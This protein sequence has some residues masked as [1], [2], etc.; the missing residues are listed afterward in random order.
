[1]NTFYE[2][3][4]RNVH[5]LSA[6]LKRSIISQVGDITEMFQEIQL[7]DINIEMECRFKGMDG[8]K[9]APRILENLDSR[10][11]LLKRVVQST[12]SNYNIP[13]YRG[14]S[15]T[16][17]ESKVD[18]ESTWMTKMKL[19]FPR[20]TVMGRTFD[21]FE[22]MG[23]KL[24]FS[25]EINSEPL[26]RVLLAS[27]GQDNTP[28]K[29]VKNRESYIDLSSGIAYDI[30]RVMQ[31][32]TNKVE[33]EIEMDLTT[34]YTNF[35][36]RDPVGTIK[37]FITRCEEE[38]RQTVFQTRSLLP[39][40]KIEDA[41]RYLNQC[42]GDERSGGWRISSKVPQ[43]RNIQTT[44]LL[45]DNYKKYAVTPKADG[46]RYFLM[47]RSSE[48]ILLQPP[49][50][51]KVLYE[52]KDIPVDWNGFIF[53]GELVEKDNWRP[54]NLTQAF[55]SQV[56]NYFCIFDV[57]GYPSGFPTQHQSDILE[58]INGVKGYFEEVRRQTSLGP[59]HWSNN[60]NAIYFQPQPSSRLSGPI[61]KTFIEIKPYDDALGTSWYAADAFFDTLLPKLR[62]KD[63]GI[64]LTPVN[65]DYQG[66]VSNMTLKWKPQ[67]MLT[68]DF[69]WADNKLYVSN[70]NS[71][72]ELVEQVFLGS[73][74]FPLDPEEVFITNP[75]KVLVKNGGIYE[76]LYDTTLRKFKVTRPRFDKT[77]PNSIRTA[78]QVW[79]D[80]HRPVSENL[81][82]GIGRDG[83]VECQKEALWSW[84]QNKISKVQGVV[85]DA[86]GIVP[87]DVFPFHIFTNGAFQT[88]MKNT[89]MVRY[90]N[91]ETN[92]DFP[93][94]RKVTPSNFTERI[95]LL[96]L[97]GQQ[98]AL[99]EGREGI[100]VGDSKKIS[101]KYIDSL[102]DLVSRSENIFVRSLPAIIPENGSSAFFPERSACGNEEELVFHYVSDDCV[103][104]DFS[105]GGLFWDVTTFT[106]SLTRVRAHKR[107]FGSESLIVSAGHRIT[108]EGKDMG[109]EHILSG[110]YFGMLW[111]YLFNVMIPSNYFHQPVS[112]LF[113]R[114]ASDSTPLED[115]F[116]GLNV[117]ADP[118]TE[119]VQ[120]V[121][122]EFVFTRS[123][124]TLRE[125]VPSSMTMER[126]VTQNPEY[127]DL[128][129]MLSKAMMILEVQTPPLNRVSYDNALV[130]KRANELRLLLG[131]INNINE[132]VK[133]IYQQ[134]DL[135]IV[136]VR[137]LKNSN[138][139][140][141]YRS[142][143]IL[144][145]TIHSPRYGFLI[146]E[147]RL[148]TLSLISLCNLLTY[149]G[150][151]LIY[152]SDPILLKLYEQ[153]LSEIDLIKNGM[154]ISPALSGRV[155]V[156]NTNWASLHRLFNSM[157]FMYSGAPE[158]N[159][160]YLQEIV[161]ET[162]DNKTSYLINMSIP[163][164]FKKQ[165]WAIT[166]QK[167][168]DEFLPR[169]RQDPAFEEK[170][171]TEFAKLLLSFTEKNRRELL[172]TGDS[173]LYDETYPNNL[174]GRG[175]M[176]F[177]NQLKE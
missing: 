89:L 96:I 32:D 132:L 13:K 50:S 22:S 62:Y 88:V 105:L 80:T 164:R 86:T 60:L 37:S 36:E 27:A 136:F 20:N 116:K 144:P 85:F 106:H 67:S 90:G 138:D 103:D 126:E 75:D 82:R 35:L 170:A 52:G 143:F 3:F 94:A 177:R 101:Q 51:Y 39:K 41:I 78:V 23:L 5:G 174:Y 30:T 148:E 17:R 43:V 135:G 110:K 65:T 15:F 29:R 123:F 53:D 172:A 44:D 128:F 112:K 113:E 176:N 156:G 162:T 159:K 152:P 42:L 56:D 129:I 97:N 26:Y 81:I 12:D 76:F 165:A 59:L 121:Q 140:T 169:I 40:E 31:S 58:R 55:L 84:F 33:T 107:L 102:R 73:S 167:K 18:G 64:I 122:E 79:N 24:A 66:L 141:S 2:T 146:V 61:R 133:T 71:K 83:M 131:G 38:A 47:I 45:K 125:N 115:L 157:R 137:R 142:R 119:L 70:R 16:V 92:I 134:L 171:E 161:S 1:M 147:S 149:R 151:M 4:E 72:G 91:L 95:E 117:E 7:S 98:V 25:L 111:D 153:P 10:S 9:A 104:I 11:S 160:E 127:G 8:A 108:P 6:D 63:D 77:V 46:Y 163:T 124:N 130:S 68:I 158:A 175:L 166:L 100:P 114:N 28:L 118:E 21:L 19:W 69:R 14:K 155:K 154:K 87:L 139:V 150:K 48:I 93:M 57:V 168:I 74:V 120:P 145:E 49:N 109:P 54:E 34:G 99:L 173:F